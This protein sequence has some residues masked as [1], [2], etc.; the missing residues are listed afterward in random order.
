MKRLMLAA[1]LIV[2]IA[3]ACVSSSNV[4]PA[5]GGGGDAGGASCQASPVSAA[6]TS[7]LSASCSA[8]TTAAGTD[9]SAVVSCTCACNLGDTCCVEACGAAVTSS[10]LNDAKNLA[11]CAT[12]SC[13][14]VCSVTVPAACNATDAGAPDTS[15][16][17]DAGTEPD[18]SDASQA[19][20][21]SDATAADASDAAADA[22]DDSP[23]DD[24]SDA[25]ATD[26]SDAAGDASDG[27]LT[28]IAL[29]FDGVVDQVV[30]PTVDGGANEAA[31]TTEVWF[32]TTN[33]TGSLFEVFGGGG[34]DRFLVVES[35][36]VCFYVYGSP[37]TLLC[38]PATT[39]ADGAWHH[40][41]GTLGVING[42]CLYVDGVLSVSQ[43]TPTSSAFNYDTNFRLGYGHTDLNSTL[44]YFGGK[45]DEVRVW[46]IER[47]AADILASYKTHLPGTTPGL[48]GYWKLDGSGASTTATDSTPNGNDGVLENFTFAPSP[49]VAGGAF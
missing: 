42:M 14:S 40:A 36:A 21:G 48:Q 12:A 13:A 5:G 33:P 10:C 29:E 9:C 17:T 11:T 1:G 23:G 44:V 24:A 41:A 22:S 35:G 47:T 25:A 45:L 32:N 30:M 4:P 38:S 16:P 46:S 39:Y 26:A 18:A 31:F 2:A 37:T 3:A 6:C 20:A 15:V 8:Q 49:W 19:D 34:A 43:A 27:G 7:C 28:G